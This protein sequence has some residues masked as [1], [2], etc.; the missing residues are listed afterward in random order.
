MRRA[1]L[2]GAGHN[3]L[4]LGRYCLAVSCATSG[5]ARRRRGGGFC[6]GESWPVRWT[7]GD[8]RKRERI[9]EIKEKERKGN[10]MK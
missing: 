2:G 3:W 6:E 9:K 7:I 1:Q 4:G 8:G 5:D 10:E